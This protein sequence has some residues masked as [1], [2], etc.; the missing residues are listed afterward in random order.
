MCRVVVTPAAFGRDLRRSLLPKGPI[1]Y[2][3]GLAVLAALCD[4]AAQ[5]SFHLEFAGPVANAMP[6][7]TPTGSQTTSDA[8]TLSRPPAQAVER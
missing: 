2:L 7:P 8:G 5:L 4:G 1:G 3:L 6:T